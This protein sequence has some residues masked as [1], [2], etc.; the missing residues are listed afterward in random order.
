MYLNKTLF[1]LLLLF[2]TCLL[3]AQNETANWYFGDNA[4][5]TFNS[6]TPVAL[7]DGQLSTTE[8]CA[9]ISNSSGQLLFYTDGIT[10]WDKTHAIMPNGTDLLGDPSSSQSAIIVPKPGSINTYYIFTVDNEGGPNGLQYSEL[11]LSLNSGNGDVTANKNVLLSTPTS[12]KIS[13]VQHANGV[14]FWVITH[15]FDNSIFLAYEVTA[16]GVNTTAIESNSGTSHG[17]NA[18]DAIGCL[19]FSPNGERLAL[20]KSF[21]SSFVEIFNFD[22]TSGIVTDPINLTGMFYNLTSEGGA[23]G[24]EFSLDSNLLY[25]TDLNTGTGLSRIHQFNLTLNNQTD[26]SNSDF[27]LYD[28]NGL[29][30]SLQLAIDEKIYIARAESTFLSAIDNPNEIGVSANFVNNAV[31]LNSLSAFG[32]PPFIQ[33]YFN[34]GIQIENTCFGGQTQFSVNST[35]AIFSIEW[36]FGDGTTSSDENPEHTYSA[37]GSY[38]VIVEVSSATETLSLTRTVEI[39]GVPTANVV[40]N[41]KLCDDSSNNGFEIFDL[42]SKSI[43]VYGGQSTSIFDLEFYSS[44]EDAENRINALPNSY[45]NTANPE[46]VYAT[47]FNTNNASC[48]IISTFELIVNTSPISSIVGD[49]RLCDDEVVDGLEL[50]DLGLLDPAVLNGQSSTVFSISYHINQDDADNNASPLDIPYQTITNPQII[51][52][53]IENINNVSCF[54]T[55]EINIIVDDQLIAYQPNNMNVCDDEIFDGFETFTLNLQNPQISNGQTGSFEISYHLNEEDAIADASPLNNNYL[56]V[57][58]P[59]TV[60]A[61][62]ENSTNLN[63]FDVTSFQLEVLALPDIVTQE[64]YYLCT[65]ETIELEADEG[66]DYYNWSTGATTRAIN[67]DGE[68]TYTVEIIDDFQTTPPISCSRI[69]TFTVIESDAAE[70]ISIQIDDWSQNNNTVAVFVDGIGDYEYS[71]DGF[72]YQNSNTFTSL[73]PGTYTVFVRDINNCGIVSE[74]V[75]LLYYPK[76]FTPNGDA[77]NPTWQIINASAE[78]DLEVLIFDRYGKLLAEF[79]GSS[80]GW[81]GTYG[82]QNMPAADYWFVVKRPGNGKTYKGHF[83]LKR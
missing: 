40:S 34:V 83:A 60:Y 58:N 35:E 6:G 43:E 65:G 42:S 10:V 77:Y 14:D 53:R 30:G 25:V 9:T 18:P 11:D 39:F 20:A 61:R 73:S 32:L 31:N 21:S 33:S 1:C 52:A 54:S 56:N 74:E 66:Y 51:Y 62:I 38:D 82:G 2:S 55:T 3:T 41:Y 28:G 70:I 15:G 8:G 76:F 68:G 16:A 23:Y 49:F 5:V 44:L 36:D 69:K 27:I 75:F 64:T 17:G 29:F 26:I 67:I 71:L 37:V 22:A 50:V 46:L 78:R 47:L 80:I 79:S 12:E 72:S 24:I 59:Q 7:L 48:Y 57:S 13:A 81:D 4:G 45:T 19:K 63:C